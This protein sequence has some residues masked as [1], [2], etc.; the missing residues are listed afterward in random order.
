MGNK[1]S[2]FVPGEGTTRD[3]L[4]KPVDIKVAILGLDAAGKTT[5]LYQLA[6]G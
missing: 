6:K 3:E 4:C 1:K 5:M 2:K